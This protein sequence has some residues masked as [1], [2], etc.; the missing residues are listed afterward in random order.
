MT[1]GNAY[2]NIKL[3]FINVMI[4]YVVVY[5]VMIPFQDFFVHESKNIIIVLSLVYIRSFLIYTV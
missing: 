4:P 2:I 3:K 1:Y 5:N